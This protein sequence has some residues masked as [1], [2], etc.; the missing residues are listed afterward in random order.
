MKAWQKISRVARG[1][2]HDLF[3]EG[4]PDENTPSAADSLAAQSIQLAPIQAQLDALAPEL[5]RLEA[6]QRQSQAG[7]AQLDADLIALDGE[8]DRALLGGDEEQA[9][10]LALRR[11]EVQQQH[12]E[13]SQRYQE[14]ARITALARG[15]FEKMRKRLGEA[16]RQLAGLSEREQDAQA[17]ENLAAVRRELDAALADLKPDEKKSLTSGRTPKGDSQ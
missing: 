16:H 7:L 9:R 14:Q 15:V 4:E 12:A 2:F 6:R 13:L 11:L 1:I 3:G 8:A 10:R 5:A 17:L